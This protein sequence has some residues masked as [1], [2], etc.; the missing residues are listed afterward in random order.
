MAVASARGRSSSAASRVGAA[1]VTSL[2]LVACGS[3]TSTAGS[4]SGATGTSPTAGAQPNATVVRIVDGDTI[5]ASVGGR[6]QRIRFIGMNTP[7]SVDPRR[8]VECFGHEASAHLKSLL[9]AGDRLRLVRDVEPR[10]KYGRLLAYVYRS[11]DGLFVNL[12]QVSDGYAQV[13]TI[14]PNIAH[15][16]DFRVAERQAREAH[17]GLWSAC[18]HQ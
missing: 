15:V 14:P 11:S 13:L 17:R 7:E 12:T 1:L 4:S 9:H 2:L 3:D 5:I 10:D 6:D 16:D 8:P 18:L